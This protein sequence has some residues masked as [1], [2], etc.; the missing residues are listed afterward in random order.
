MFHLDYFF[1]SALPPASSIEPDNPRVEPPNL[2]GDSEDQTVPPL[3]PNAPGTRFPPPPMFPPHQM[4]PRLPMP[5]QPI[6]RP[7][8]PR[9]PH[10]PP[11]PP[12]RF[13]PPPPIGFPPRGFPA[14]PPPRP[15]VHYPS[16]DPH[17]MGTGNE[18]T[19]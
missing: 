10:F 11:G 18:G 4:P 3:P 16:Q 6:N 14:V 17:R 7:P 12:P 5:G 8:I 15:Q 19:S 13:I 9:P 1:T 2:F